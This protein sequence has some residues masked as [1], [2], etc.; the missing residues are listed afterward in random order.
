MYGGLTCQLN[1]QK[2]EN[3]EKEKK[4]RVDLFLCHVLSEPGEI[5]MSG[6]SSHQ[7]KLRGPLQHEIF[8]GRKISC[9]VGILKLL[10]FVRQQFLPTSSV[11]I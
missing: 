11:D 2:K 8:I 4:K 5:T 10:I 7:I 3:M 1:S 9:G 6:R